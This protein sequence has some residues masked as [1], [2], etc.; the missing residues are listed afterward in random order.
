MVQRITNENAACLRR[1]CSGVM[2]TSSC[3]K[4]FEVEHC[5]KNQN[6]FLTTKRLDKHFQSSLYGNAPPYPHGCIYLHVR[7]ELNYDAEVTELSYLLQLKQMRSD[8]S[9]KKK[10][11]A[12]NIRLSGDTKAGNL[13]KNQG[14]SLGIESPLHD[15][16]Q[17]NLTKN[18]ICKK[19][20][21]EN[22]LRYRLR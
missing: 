18:D 21:R 16:L 11:P 12:K 19:V 5:K 15:A 2:R 9:Q 17:K 3:C 4:S 10:N 13:V 20:S 8:G 7:S 14:K 6:R 22:K 1:T